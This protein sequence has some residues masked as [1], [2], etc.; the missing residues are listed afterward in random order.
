MRFFD[1]VALFL[2]DI[3]ISA[4]TSGRG[5]IL[6]G[7]ILVIIYLAFLIQPQIQEIFYY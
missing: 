7:G 3:E 1:H 6:I 5:S 4:T 2:Q